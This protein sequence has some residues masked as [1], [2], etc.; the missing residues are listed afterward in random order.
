M[1]PC[2]ILQDKGPLVRTDVYEV[3][4]AAM[5]AEG[6]AAAASSAAALDAVA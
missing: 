2:L 4:L 3:A 5:E 6:T 1:G